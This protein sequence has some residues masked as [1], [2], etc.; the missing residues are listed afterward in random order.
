MKGGSSLAGP[1]KTRTSVPASRSSAIPSHRS[2]VSIIF[3]WKSRSTAL[4]SACRMAISSGVV[5]YG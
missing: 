4:R 3:S 2:S 1:R 5:S